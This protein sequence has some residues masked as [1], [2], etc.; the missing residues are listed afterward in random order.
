MKGI[1][2]PVIQLIYVRKKSGRVY[3]KLVRE[4]GAYD[5]RQILLYFI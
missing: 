2:T 4:T 1:G 5:C 3:S